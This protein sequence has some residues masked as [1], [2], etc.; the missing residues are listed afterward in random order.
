V[1]RTSWCRIGEYSRP[2]VRITERKFYQ[3][4][5]EMFK[6]SIFSLSLSPSLSLSLSLF[7]C[8][9]AFRLV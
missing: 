3:L 1:T 4:K 9:L 2:Q 8:F 6:M 7:F 5:Y